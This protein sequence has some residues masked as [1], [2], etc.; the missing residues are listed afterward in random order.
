[1]G[2]G[3]AL[4]AGGS[5]PVSAQV[6]E[7]ASFSTMS[8]GA[9]LGARGLLCVSVLLHLSGLVGIW[10]GWYLSGRVSLSFS[11]C[12]PVLAPSLFLSLLNCCFLLY[13]CI[14]AVSRHLPVTL[15]LLVSEISV[16]S[17]VC[18]CVP[19]PGQT[20]QCPT[21]AT[22]PLGMKQ[23]VSASCHTHTQGPS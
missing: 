15:H 7:D 14:F 2:R 11:G 3:R 6:R 16:A 13:L 5:L 23:V 10:L 1:M 8:R 18:L 22:A 20:Q 19:S 17:D 12:L 4:P 21:L 9:G